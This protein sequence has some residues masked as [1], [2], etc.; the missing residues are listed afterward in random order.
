MEIHD[1][2]DHAKIFLSFKLIHS[3]VKLLHYTIIHYPFT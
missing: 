2:L 3:Q 1:L